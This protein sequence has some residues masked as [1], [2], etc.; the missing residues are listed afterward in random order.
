MTFH[1][2]GENKCQEC[3]DHGDHGLLCQNCRENE[4]YGPPPCTCIVCRSDMAGIMP[5]L[6]DDTSG[7]GLERSK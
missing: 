1:P 6:M 2:T 3:G 7:D 5:C 4:G